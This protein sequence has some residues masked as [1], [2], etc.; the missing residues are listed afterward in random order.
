MGLVVD[1]QTLSLIIDLI[2]LRT[3]EELS[4]QDSTPPSTEND[5]EYESYHK[6]V[7]KI[8]NDWR[9]QSEAAA[10]ALSGGNSQT[11]S[12]SQSRSAD[13]EVAQP[14]MMFDIT[15]ENLSVSVCFWR[16]YL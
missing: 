10:A 11:I 2:T 4:S 13:N 12:S 16:I 1:Q 5:E 15:L 9:Q 14:S 7:W 3:N 6:R 8:L